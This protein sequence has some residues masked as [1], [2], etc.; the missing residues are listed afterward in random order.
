VSEF[1]LLIEVLDSIGEFNWSDAIF[2]PKDE[3]WERNTM[4]A[5]LDPDDVE[6]DSDECPLFA[7]KNNLVYSLDVQIT[8][9]IVQNAK[10]QVHNITK[11]D[12]LVAF[13]YYYDNDAY[14]NFEESN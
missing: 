10:A 5:V 6:D 14:I 3:V 8:K 11:E 12:L 4:C 13:L 7:M 1:K 9:S 2:L